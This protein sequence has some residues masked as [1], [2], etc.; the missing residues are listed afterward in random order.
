QEVVHTN[1][2]PVLGTPNGLYAAQW[3]KKEDRPRID[4]AIF[5]DK[6]SRCWTLHDLMHV[7]SPL[8]AH[9]DLATVRAVPWAEAIAHTQLQSYIFELLYRTLRA[10]I[11]GLPITF[12]KARTRYYFLPKAG[13]ARTWRYQSLRRKAERKVAHPFS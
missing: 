11:R 9:L 3:N 2:L 7:S 12:D 6:E 10:H 13:Q 5:I 4:G 1:L 8:R